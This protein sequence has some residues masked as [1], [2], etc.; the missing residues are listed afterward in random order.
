M[1]LPVIAIS[2]EYGSGGRA[3]GEQAARALG[4]P[5]YDNELILQT[6][7]ETGLSEEYIRS[8]E[9]T[10]ASG[11]FFGLGAGARQQAND[12]LFEVQSRI[13]RQIAEK[14]PCVIVGRC[15]DYILRD[16]EDLLSVFI[17]API[18]LRAKRAGEVYGV[19]ADDLE[20]YV[21]KEDKRRAAFYSHVTKN[22]WG[23]A[24]RY[25]MA[26]STVYGV[27]YAV[28]ILKNAALAFARQREE[29]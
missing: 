24:S 27:D 23:D 18:E 15:G 11:F 16:R 8:T 2:R 19:E 4:I 14:G 21:K 20:D 17:H 10:K 3:V 22:K 5:F 25:R 26:L 7:R 6:A 29:A 12:E 28:E 1:K 13:I 9:E